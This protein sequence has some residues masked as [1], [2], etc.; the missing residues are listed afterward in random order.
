VAEIKSFADLEMLDDY[1]M[2]KLNRL[3]IALAAF[4]IAFTVSIGVLAWAFWQTY[5]WQ[6][7]S[8]VLAQQAGEE[9]A[10]NCF[11]SGKLLVYEFGGTNQTFEFSGRRDGVFEIWLWPDYINQPMPFRRGQRKEMEVFNEKMR[12]MYNHPKFFLEGYG[13]SNFTNKNHQ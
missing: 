5:N 7:S 10:L 2:E 11:R 8:D 3:K 4:G 1:L 12:Y 13:T 9:Y 6:Y